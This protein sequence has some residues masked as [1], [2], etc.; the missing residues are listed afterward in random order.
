METDIELIQNY[1]QWTENL[2]WTWHR[3]KGIHRCP[4]WWVSE[5]VWTRHRREDTY[6]CTES[7]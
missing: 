3:R 5:P 2:I 1:L 4:S 7:L 6:R